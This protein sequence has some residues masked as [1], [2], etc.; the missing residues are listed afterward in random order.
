MGSEHL[1]INLTHNDNIKTFD[2]V[3]RHVELEEGHLLNDKPVRQAYMIG[4]KKFGASMTGRKK[5]KGKGFKPR[6]GGSKT[7]LSRHKCKH[8]KRAGK[9]NQNKNCF[10]CGKIGH[11]AHDCTKPKVKYD[12]IHFYDVFIS[13]C[14]MLIETVSFWIVDS[15][16]TDH[17]GR[18]RNAYVDFHRILKGSRS[19][20][21][22]NNTSADVLRIGTCKLIMRKGCTLYLHDV[23]YAPEIRRNLVSLVVLVKLG[24]KIAFE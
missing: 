24:F 2:D 3:A 1:R 23:L 19:I 22:G 6:K 17:I 11:F 20:Y 14:L 7:I 10:N 16:T 18:D 13:S 21:M 5:W 4:S 12:Q 8:E 15:T 9:H